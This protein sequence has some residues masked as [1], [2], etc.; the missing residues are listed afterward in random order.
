MLREAHREGPRTHKRTL[1]NLSALPA[2][3]L[4]ALRAA[5]KGEPLVKAT[6]HFAVEKS[7]PCGHVRAI[8]GAMDQLKMTK[9]IA[10]KPFVERD[11]V[12]ALIAQR[13]LKPG[14]K[15]ETA[16]RFADTTLAA[17][18]AVEGA[19]EDDLYAAM[20]GLLDRQPFIE[21][22]LAAR[23]LAEGGAAPTCAS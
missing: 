23:H 13:V 16:A 5:L 10:V 17:D 1:A 2:P 8:Q 18:F 7:L 21:Q 15:L 6:E 3:A 22:K 20:D 9:W 14:S 11:R 19:D 12:L 4:A